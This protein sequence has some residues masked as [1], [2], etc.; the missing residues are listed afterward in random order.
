MCSFSCLNL[1]MTISFKISFQL[2]SLWALTDWEYGGLGFSSSN[3]GLAEGAAG[4]T[5][6]SENIES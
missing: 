2:F 4:L 1:L 3:V 6:V 5:L